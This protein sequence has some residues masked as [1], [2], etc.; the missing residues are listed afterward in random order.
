MMEDL[1]GRYD[2]KLSTSIG[3]FGYKTAEIEDLSVLIGL[4]DQDMYLEKRRKKALKTKRINV[5]EPAVSARGGSFRFFQ[6][7]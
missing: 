4:T 1:S 6:N 5:F 7:N 3:G 2:I